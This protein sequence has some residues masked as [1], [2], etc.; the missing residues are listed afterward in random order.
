MKVIKRSYPGTKIPFFHETLVRRLGGASC[1]K[2][3]SYKKVVTGHKA[4]LFHALP[5]A[6]D[7][8][9][10]M[11]LS[12]QNK[13]IDLH[14]HS[15]NSDGCDTTQALLDQLFSLDVQIISFT[16]HDSVGC[17]YDLQGLVNIYG[18]SIT[19]IKGCEFSFVYNNRIKHMLG[20]GI[21]IDYIKS[22]LDYQYS[23]K[24]RIEKQ[25]EY[26][27]RFKAVCKSKGM[28]FDDSVTVSTGKTSEAFIALYYELN[29][30]P[31]NILRFPFIVDNTILYWNYYA[32]IESEY[33]VSETK[34][35]TSMEEILDI[36]KKAG[37][38]AF[39]A[40]PYAYMRDRTAN[41]ELLKHAIK[42]GIDGIEIQHS[43]NKE[44]D[45]DV[46]TEIALSHKLLRSGGSDFHG[47]IKPALKLVFGYDNMQVSFDEI[48]EWIDKAGK[49]IF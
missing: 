7:W 1:A 28:I 29:K 26:L 40:H 30:H 11:L 22:F 46:L 49:I 37:G 16:D 15:V 21:D 20:Y 24:S 17:Y 39:L 31:E 35:I 12:M 2:F 25:H 41:N 32:N 27:D 13:Y 44:D 47:K 45:V 23:L 9:R 14:M 43:S 48:S 33:Y 19:V 36:I 6:G 18:K 34:G 3:K 8:R 38:L 4:P 42:N 10:I 5:G